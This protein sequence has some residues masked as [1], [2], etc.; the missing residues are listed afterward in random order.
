MTNYRKLF[1]E[2]LRTLRRQ[3]RLSQLALSELLGG[4]PGHTQISRYENGENLPAH[5]SN[6]ESIAF[7][8]GCTVA[9]KKRLIEAYAKAIGGDNGIDGLLA[10]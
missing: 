3:R 4:K 10:F 6:V 5:R 8:M 2:N 7:A 9:E 1:G